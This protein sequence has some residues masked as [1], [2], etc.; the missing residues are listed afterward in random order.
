MILFR[1]R[2]DRVKEA[3]VNTSLNYLKNNNVCNSKQ[4]KIFRYTLESLYSLFT[5]SAVILV[6]AIILGTFKITFITLLLYCILRGFTFGIHATKNI[7]CWIIS[8]SVYIFGPFAIKYLTV[9]N[10]ILKIVLLINVLAILL[11]AP[12]DTKARPLIS[13]RKR[14]TNKIIALVY[15]FVLI[16]ILIVLNSDIFTK[17]ICFIGL[18]NTVCTCPLTYYIFKQPYRNYKSYKV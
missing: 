16:G 10:L 8:L 13:R 7:Y 3:F 17:I 11:W 15:M 9:P 6:L 14:I 4:E 5:K 12:A 1:Q 18:L 2:G